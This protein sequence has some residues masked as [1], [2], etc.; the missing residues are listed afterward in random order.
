MHQLECLSA[1]DEQDYLD[2]GTE[3]PFDT[4]QEL[5]GRTDKV[6]FQYLGQAYKAWMQGDE[7]ATEKL[8]RTL[9]QRFAIDDNFGEQYIKRI[10]DLNA[11]IRERTNKIAR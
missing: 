6:F 4:R 11:S 10:A 1:Q 7:V 3:T 5:L 9:E 8:E 2:S